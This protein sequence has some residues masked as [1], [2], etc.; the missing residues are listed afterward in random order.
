M[1]AKEILSVQHP[2]IKRM[3]SLR[4]E[5][6]SREKEGAVLL[7]GKK[8]ISDLSRIVSFELLFYLDEPL[9]FPAKESIRVSPS[10]LKKIT[11]LE[12]PDGWAA[13]AP[14]PPPRSLEKKNSILILDRLSDPG[15]LG[16]LWRTAFG[17]GW[18]GIWL[19][20]GT[21]DPFND[22]A[23]RAARG[24]TFQLP[25]DWVEPEKILTWG[26]ERHAHIYVADLEGP[27]P[28]QIK[29]NPPLALVLS[30]EGSGRARWTNSLP[31]ITIPMEKSLESL[32][33]ACAGSIL[34]YTLRP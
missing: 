8:M 11:G 18:E 1:V 24:T 5:K 23:L 4:L 27:S 30:T 15:N 6:K 3:V 12:E 31:P 22:K 34:L 25:Y 17:L 20:P 2:L 19:T 9:P 21:V 7:S 10:V 33:V 13:V 29:K 26:K 32:N 28:D 16:T 14:L